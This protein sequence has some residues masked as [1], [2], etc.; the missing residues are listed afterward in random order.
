MYCSYSNISIYRRA[1]LAVYFCHL[2]RVRLSVYQLCHIASYQYNSTE[3]VMRQNL[4]ICV[5]RVTSSYVLYQGFPCMYCHMTL[6]D[7]DI[8][9]GVCRWLSEVVFLLSW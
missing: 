5:S 3:A 9:W 4:P 8:V 2:L 7:I 6:S 1:Y